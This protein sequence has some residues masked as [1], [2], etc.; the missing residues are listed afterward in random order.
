MKRNLFYLLP[1]LLILGEACSPKSDNIP[2]LSPSG[3]FKGKFRMSVKNNSTG[4]VDS[5]VKDTAL[6]LKLTAPY[7]F[8]VTGDTATIHAGS[9]GNFGYDGNFM[10]FLDSTYKA[11]PQAKR[12]LVGD[13]QYYYNGTLL[14]L[15]RVNSSL[16]TV[17]RYD[18]NKTSN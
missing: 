15:Q 16:D 18:F 11:G 3:T 2:I 10:R 5:S 14:Q 7:H 4:V 17:L 8:A 1:L 9:K 13:Y 12:H 6:I